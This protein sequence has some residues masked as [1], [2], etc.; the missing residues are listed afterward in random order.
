MAGTAAAAFGAPPEATEEQ[1]DQRGTL[2][3]SKLLLRAKLKKWERTFGQDNPPPA[4][5]D[6]AKKETLLKE[7]SKA[8]VCMMG[9]GWE[10]GWECVCAMAT[11]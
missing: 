6:Q 5:K 3:A 1:E 7:L 2:E 4:K 9:I 8:R 11:L 10:R